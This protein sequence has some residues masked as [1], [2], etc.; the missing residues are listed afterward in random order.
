VG[1]P[2]HRQAL[3]ALLPPVRQRI[4]YR[5]EVSMSRRGERRCLV[6][7]AVGIWKLLEVGAVEWQMMKVEV[8]FGGVL[9]R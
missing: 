8:V 5:L 2:P 6:M 9:R 1:F 7:S 4:L 3:K